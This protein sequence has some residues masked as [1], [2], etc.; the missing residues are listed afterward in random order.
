MSSFAVEI[1]DLSPPG[2]ILEEALEERSMPSAELARRTGL[3]EKH[4][5]QL[6]NAKA[7]LS[8][9]VALQLE[10]VLGIPARLWNSLEFNY[11]AEL[12][13]HAE[14]KSLTKFAAWQTPPVKVQNLSK[15]K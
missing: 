11:R 13:R 5:S 10:R 6:I 1:Q 15:K 9:E 12:Q 2:E 3:S 14:R 4:I 7:P 8:M